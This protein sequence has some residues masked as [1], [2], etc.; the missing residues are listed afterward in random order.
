MGRKK[1]SSDEYEPL[2]EQEAESNSEQ[3]QK[4]A[5]GIGHF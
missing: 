3:Q 4:Q 1:D 5:P 2:D